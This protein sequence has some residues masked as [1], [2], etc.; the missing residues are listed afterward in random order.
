MASNNVQT[1]PISAPVECVYCAL[2]MQAV[3]VPDDG[4]CTGC[5]GLFYGQRQPR[6]VTAA[7]PRV[8]RASA[9]AQPKKNR[10]PIIAGSLVAL[11][12]LGYFVTRK[13]TRPAPHHTS[14]PVG[15]IA[16]PEAK[17]E[18]ITPVAP[19]K[20]T[21]A[22]SNAIEAGLYQIRNLID[23]RVLD[24]PAGEIAAGAP[25]NTYANGDNINQKFILKPAVS[26]HWRILA[27]HSYKAVGA[28]GTE[29][30][31]MIPAGVPQ[32]RWRIEKSA[33]GAFVIL[34]EANRMALTALPYAA[35][36]KG[37]GTTLTPPD[38]SDAQAW[39]FVRI[40]PTPADFVDMAFVKSPPT[41]A[42]A[43][44]FSVQS[45]PFPQKFVPLDFSR[46][47]SAD[48]RRGLFSDPTK[49]DCTVHPLQFG[50]LNIAGVTFTV[51]DPSQT[52]GG[53][54]VIVLRGGDGYSKTTHPRV[55][56]LPVANIALTRL[57]IVGGVAGWGWPF[58]KKPGESNAGA[59][60]AKIT[61][62]RA[63][64][65]TEQFILRNGEV[66]C[67]YARTQD[68]PGSSRITGLAAHNRQMRYFS[69]PLTGTGPV[70]KIM[71]ESFNNQTAPVFV[72]VTG[73]K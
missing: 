5:G 72:A 54:N 39:K 2:Q 42:P 70:T 47:A 36:A 43:V 50:T 61:V 71:L 46:A 30:V 51:L 32:Q 45:S 56:H 38:R 27:M 34:S 23:S 33:G 55:A 40:G 9:P 63:S 28:N 60:V 65:A 35:D 14:T 52:T 20:P 37:G 44:S 19:P 25:I 73:E 41:G 13:G 58:T 4:V 12:A 67:D 26:G 29:V 11:A 59:V 48:S 64:G 15:T 53:K 69:I 21:V 66:F 3:S 6:A 68:V 22:D 7:V 49:L 10:L 24:V 31:Q 16:Q 57:H 62:T 1:Q 18:P 8:V 17:P